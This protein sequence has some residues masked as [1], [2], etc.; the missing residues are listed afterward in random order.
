[1]RSIRREHPSITLI[2]TIGVLLGAG[3]AVGSPAHPPRE[4]RP[5]PAA[6]TS[7]AA[8][9]ATSAATPGRP[10][11]PPQG[12]TA[13]GTPPASPTP[14][15]IGSA[16]PS[17]CQP[18]ASI[19]GLSGPDTP[20]AHALHVLAALCDDAHGGGVRSAIDH[21]GDEHERDHR[22]SDSAEPRHRADTRASDVRDA[23]PSGQRGGGMSPSVPERALA[24]PA[25]Q[26]LDGVGRG[27]GSG[28]GPQA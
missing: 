23:R 5:S 17:G 1:M 25:A 12:S 13:T 4:N 26:V 21:I 27:K 7:S 19:P 28:A 11:R 14:S 2:V 18:V 16:Q 10:S 15:R 9:S 20:T 22:H 6:A 24:V 3:L 8:R